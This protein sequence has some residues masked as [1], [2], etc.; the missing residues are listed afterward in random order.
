MKSM[1][2]KGR[3]GKGSHRQKGLERETSLSKHAPLS[4][5]A[6]AASINKQL[7]PDGE[8]IAPHPNWNAFLGTILS[9]KGDRAGAAEHFRNYLTS[10]GGELDVAFIMRQISLVSG[11]AAGTLPVTKG[12]STAELVSMVRSALQGRARDDRL[13]RYLRDTGLAERLDDR[14]VETLE[15]EGAGPQTV[16]ELLRLRDESVRR[17]QPASPVIETP[18]AP[19]P[20]EQEQIWAAAAQSSLH[21][22]ESLPNFLCTEVVRRY[23]DPN[24]RPYDTLQLRLTYFDRKEDYQLITAR[25]T[26]Q[27]TGGATT[28][29]EFGSLLTSIFS[30]GSLLESHWDHWTTLRKRRT[31]VYYFRTPL[32]Q[33]VYKIE[34]RP[35]G[36]GPF[37]ST[38][39]SQQGFVYIHAETERVVRILCQA[40]NVP[41]NF[42]VQSAASRV[43]YDF[44]DVGGNSYLLPV[45]AQIRVD[46]PAEEHRNEVA[47][48][49]YRKFTADSNIA[50]GSVKN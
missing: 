3:P 32:A 43:D 44:I 5:R 41:L 27:Q 16:A 21:Y 34:F 9:D 7:D 14:T 45:A 20:E 10:C 42:P 26:Y 31:L 2:A 36:A 38:K 33:S 48:R 50:F 47:F 24:D 22:A 39:A 12:T 18:A 15:S 35:S 19:S 49:D 23:L 6:K 11:P 40:E 25:R 8:L 30:I 46:S 37:S 1:P 28:R 4:D 13:A 17:P 29:G